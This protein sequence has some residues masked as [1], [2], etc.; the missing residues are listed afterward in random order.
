M[1]K[2]FKTSN[3]RII[4]QYFTCYCNNIIVTH[5]YTC[6]ARIHDVTSIKQLT[7][8]TSYMTSVAIALI[9]TFV[10]Q[11]MLF[12]HY[13]HVIIFFVNNALFYVIYYKNLRYSHLCIIVRQ[14]M[15]VKTR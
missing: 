10:G 6:S 15:T 3:S 7:V 13:F 11:L 1:T 5:A 8:H 12:K 9:Y 14:V 4:S 2:L